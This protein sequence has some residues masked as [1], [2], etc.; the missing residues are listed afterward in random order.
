MG[1]REG[2]INQRCITDE[3][4]QLTAKQKQTIQLARNVQRKD[5]RVLN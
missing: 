1:G 2:R 5:V 3:R 4:R